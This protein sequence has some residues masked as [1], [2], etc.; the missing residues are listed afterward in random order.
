MATASLT[1]K[2]KSHPSCESAYCLTSSNSSKATVAASWAEAA[3]KLL[4]LLQ[5][6]PYSATPHAPF[7]DLGIGWTEHLLH[8]SQGSQWQLQNL[9]CMTTHLPEHCSHLLV[10]QVGTLHLHVVL[11]MRQDAVALSMDK[12]PP[13]A[14][15]ARVRNACSRRAEDA[16]SEES[17]AMML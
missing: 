5:L 11:R 8:P 9:P 4:Q 2:S 14:M 7:T 3:A 17:L 16:P 15:L 13:R 1:L 10:A 12:S 6:Q